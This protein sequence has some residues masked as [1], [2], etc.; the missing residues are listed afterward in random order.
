MN[1]L[2]SVSCA[3]KLEGA[4]VFIGLIKESLLSVHKF[5]LVSVCVEMVALC[6][7]HLEVVEVDLFASC[8]LNGFEQLEVKQLKLLVTH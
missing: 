5:L 7:E 2:C 3:T 6:V 1:L 4:G 8:Q